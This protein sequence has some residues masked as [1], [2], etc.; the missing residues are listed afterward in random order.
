MQ[1]EGKVAFI[2]GG[3]RG[4]GRSHAVRFAE[5]GADII[6]FDLCDQLDSVAYPMSTREDLDE[7][8][9]LVE[10]TGR[11][12]VAE[13]G[14]VR[15][16]D[17]LKAAVATGVAE[18]GRVDFVLANAGVLPITGEQ[19]NQVEA[20][21]DA[22]DVLLNGVYYTIEAALPAL[23]E[24][25]EGGAIV[26]TSSSAGLS[27][28]CPKFSVRS[29]GFAGYHAAKHGV[30]GLMRYFATALAEKNI[31]VNAV[32]PCGVT[33][34]MLLNDAVAQHMAEHPEGLSALENLLPV[35]MIES[36]DVT[37]AMVYLCGQSGRYVTGIT[38]PV[39]AGYT[40]K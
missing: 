5:E 8:V 15:D 17:R 11:R 34:P 20:F 9:N 33:T 3:A 19:R 12:I 13:Q 22:V 29:H 21:V 28:M 24:H 23:L 30:V 39:D 32:H 37:E 35:P 40:V 27:S 25:G 36:V 4:Q 31:R 1:F 18:L 26:I 2:T 6:A 38:L 16:F 14:D 7:T 10:K